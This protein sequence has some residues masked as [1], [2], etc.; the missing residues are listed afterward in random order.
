M[1][2]HYATLRVDA[3]TGRDVKRIARSHRMTVVETVA[4]M[5]KA[6][7]SLSA[8]QKESAIRRDENGN[9]HAP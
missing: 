4:A 1:K 9:G 2:R 3:A 6:W 8:E 5:T 7:H